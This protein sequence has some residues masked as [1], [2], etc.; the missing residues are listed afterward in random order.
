ME[1]PF[2][3]LSWTPS[4]ISNRVSFANSLMNLCNAIILTDLSKRGP[5]IWPEKPVRRPGATA[6]WHVLDISNEQAM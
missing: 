2:S 1:I 6:R 5:R 3:V 4:M